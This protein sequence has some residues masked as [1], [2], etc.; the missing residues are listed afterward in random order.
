MVVVLQG[1]CLAL[2][3]LI[4]CPKNWFFC[5]GDHTCHVDVANVSVLKRSHVRD[6]M[7]NNFI[8]ASTAALGKLKFGR[9]LL[10]DS[11]LR[12]KEPQEIKKKEN[13]LSKKFKALCT[14]VVP[15]YSRISYS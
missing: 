9:A 12:P 11:L 4:V 15:I 13:Q 10:S 8:Y 14:I 3:V 2:N 5:V 7:T 1:T 6:A